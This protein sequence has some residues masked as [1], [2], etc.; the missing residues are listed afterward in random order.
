MKLRFIR[1]A[2]CHELCVYTYM[3]KY[4]YLCVCMCVCVYVQGWK[5]ADS[6]SQMRITF[7]VN[8]N[9]FGLLIRNISGSLQISLGR[10]R[11]TF[12]DGFVKRPFLEK[13]YAIRNNSANKLQITAN[14]F[15]KWFAILRYKFRKIVNQF[16][17]CFTNFCENRKIANHFYSYFQPC[18]YLYIYVYIYTYIHAC[19]HACTHTYI[20][21]YINTC[22]WSNFTK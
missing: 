8:A 16:K 2:K 20:H 15:K 19:M 7:G 6:H 12:A 14:Q 22:V 21:T 18:I 9:Y 11:I 1:K 10:L 17:K 5:L 3:Y 4:I 13:F